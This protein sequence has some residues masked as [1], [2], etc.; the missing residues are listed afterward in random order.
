MGVVKNDIPVTNQGAVSETYG[1]V[2]ERGDRQ[3]EPTY[4]P[5]VAAILDG[6]IENVETQS[7]L[8]ACGEV[9]R[10]VFDYTFDVPQAKD[11]GPRLDVAFRKF[12]CVVWLLR[13]ELL[14]NISQMQLG[15]HLG[16]CR[17]T[18][19]KAIRLFGD[20]H[21]IRNALQKRESAREIIAPRRS[22]TIGGTGRKVVGDWAGQGTHSLRNESESRATLNPYGVGL[23]WQPRA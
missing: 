22:A 3:P 20:A 16:V 21:G 14:G 12:C 9:M 8:A 7:D 11:G 5:D 23:T 2:G 10:S 1:W 18:L 4:T 19:S 13:P 17:A 6:D 15:P